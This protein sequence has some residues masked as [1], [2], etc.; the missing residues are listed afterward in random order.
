MNN[1]FGSRIIDGIRYDWINNIWSGLSYFRAENNYLEPSS[2]PSGGTRN[3]KFEKNYFFD[4]CLTKES[5]FGGAVLGYLTFDCQLGDR[6]EMSMRRY[7][8]GSWQGDYIP[9]KINIWRQPNSQ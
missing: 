3:E 5:P 8:N 2:D 6:G 1:Y 4:N 7:A 9:A